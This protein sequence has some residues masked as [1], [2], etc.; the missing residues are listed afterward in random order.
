[1]KAAKDRELEKQTEGKMKNASMPENNR[2]KSRVI[3][4]DRSKIK[5]D[6]I[7]QGAEM[8]DKKFNLYKG[9]ENQIKAIQ[10]Q[11]NREKSINAE[12]N[13]NGHWKG[14]RG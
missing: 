8:V 9:L 7:R 6:W 11:D 5:I 13:Q 1:M 3:E 14:S 4:T 12:Q 10:I 2:N